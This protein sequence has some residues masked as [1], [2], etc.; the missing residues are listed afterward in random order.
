M[1]FGRKIDSVVD[2][3]NGIVP[4]SGI[5]PLDAEMIRI[6][7]GDYYQKMEMEFLSPG[8]QS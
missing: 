5:K 2:G 7:E 3:K 1:W 8:S 6:Y 4:Q